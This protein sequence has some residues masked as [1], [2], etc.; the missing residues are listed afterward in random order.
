MNNMV[1]EWSLNQISV[2]QLRRT[3][4]ERPSIELKLQY[5]SIL[6]KSWHASDNTAGRRRRL[7]VGEACGCRSNVQ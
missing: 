5:D 7:G 6:I 4:I 1:L 2:V 3:V